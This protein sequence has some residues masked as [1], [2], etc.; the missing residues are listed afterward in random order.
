MLR[1]CMIA[2][3]FAA[4]LLSGCADLSSDPRMGPA[5]VQGAAAS[6]RYWDGVAF[7]NDEA[8]AVLSYVNTTDVDT[9]DLD[10]GLDRRAARS[11]IKAQPIGS[12]NELSSLYFVGEV[13]LRKLKV[14]V[15]T[16]LPPVG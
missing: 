9:L 16:P 15:D 2:S 5:D 6:V 11:I 10:V 4:M 14:A 8:K 3:V 12:M 13:A 7:T 1:K